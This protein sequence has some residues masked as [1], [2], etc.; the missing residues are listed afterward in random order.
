MLTPKAPLAATPN[1]VFVPTLNV[2]VTLNG[3]GQFTG[4]VGQLVLQGAVVDSTG[5]AAPVGPPKPCAPFTFAFDASG[6]VTGLPAEL[7]PASAAIATA[8]SAIEAAVDAINTIRK[9]V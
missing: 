1:A 3:Q 9:I 8:F 6:N 7:V 2:G 5:K 4:K